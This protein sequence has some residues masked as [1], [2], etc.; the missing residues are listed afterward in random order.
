MIYR[1]KKDDT[2]TS[3]S[4]NDNQTSDTTNE[5]NEDNKTSDATSESNNDGNSN[6]SETTDSE[7]PPS[8]SN[9]TMDAEFKKEDNQ[10]KKEAN[11]K[12]K[13]YPK[14]GEKKSTVIMVVGVGLIAIALGM[15][16]WRKRRG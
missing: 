7:E 8:S 9:T 4:N 10:F 3:E 12:L 5:S 14:T 16:Y 2:S 1:Y 6:Y 11:H 13:S 15:V